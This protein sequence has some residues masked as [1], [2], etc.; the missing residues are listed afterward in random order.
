[1]AMLFNQH[2]PLIVYLAGEIHT[3]WRVELAR[4]IE[5]H[6]VGARLVSPVTDHSASDACGPTILGEQGSGFWGD[7][8][9]AGVNAIRTRTLIAAADLIIARFSLAYRQYFEWNCAFD[10]GRA[11]A[12]G[13]P[14]ITVHPAELDHPL[15][16]VDRG[17]LAVA[18]HPDQVAEIL[19]YTFGDLAPCESLAATG[20][21]AA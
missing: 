5:R 9:S 13:K 15:K 11:V 19:A 1:M 18:R 21:H 8:A 10:A 3:D 17:A 20:A 7:Q 2:R 4:A 12:L 16:E 14:L 6:G